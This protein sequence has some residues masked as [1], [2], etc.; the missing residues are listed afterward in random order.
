MSKNV[1]LVSFALNI[2]MTFS[3]LGLSSAVKCP[4]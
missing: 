2:N 3:R 4:R 1:L